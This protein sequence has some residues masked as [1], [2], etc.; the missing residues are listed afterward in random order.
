M[1][2]RSRRLT[3][4]REFRAVYRSGA[5]RRHE[6]LVCLALSRE[7]ENTRAG[8]VASRKVGGAVERNRAKRRLRAALAAVWRE[9]PAR[10][11]H[12]VLVATAATVALDYG[13]LVEILRCSLGE[14]GVL[15]SQAPSTSP[16]RPSTEPE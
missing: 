16:P 1:L 13:R 9:L 3:K 2:R 4:D 14:L 8:V 7:G 12:V 10:G 15:G 6:A 11:W 5:S